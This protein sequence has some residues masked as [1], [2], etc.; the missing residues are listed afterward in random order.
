[1]RSLSHIYTMEVELTTHL[2]YPQ[3][4]H[5]Q[6]QLCSLFKH[7]AQA[8]RVGRCWYLFAALVH[9]SNTIGT[10]C[11]QYASDSSCGRWRIT[12]TYSVTQLFSWCKTVVAIDFN[13]SLTTNPIQELPSVVFGILFCGAQTFPTKSCESSGENSS[14]LH[15]TRHPLC[16]GVHG[17]QRKKVKKYPLYQVLNS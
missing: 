12:Q 8:Q 1:M 11:L 15:Q 5:T 13:R 16:Y 3:G 6:D 10:G 17:S 2:Y 7:Q 9:P 14:F 4:G